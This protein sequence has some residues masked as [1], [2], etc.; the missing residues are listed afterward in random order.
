MPNSPQQGLE[1]L[2]ASGNQAQ[3]SGIQGVQRNDKSP[4]FIESRAQLQFSVTSRH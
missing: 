2:A 4:A 3:E 1:T